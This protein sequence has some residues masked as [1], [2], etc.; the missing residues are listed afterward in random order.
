MTVN[1][2]KPNSLVSDVVEYYL[3]TKAFARLKG[4]TQKE[5]EGSLKIALETKTLLGKTL[6]DTRLNKLE[7]KCANHLY[8]Q[9]LDRGISR[10]NKIST[11]TSIIFNKAISLKI[12]Y[13]NPMI[14]IDRV[15]N[16]ERKVMWTPEQVNLFLD[17]AYSQWKWRPI[18]LIVHMT[19]EWAQRLGDMRLM[20]WDKID[21]DKK[22]MDLTQSKRNADVH[23]PISNEL[24]HVLEQQYKS[25][26]FQDFVAPQIVHSD[27]LYK[28]YMKGNLSSY[29][30]S[31]KE[32]AGLPAE[33]TA[34]DMRRTAITEMVEAGVDVLQIKQVSGHKNIQSLD[35][36]LKHTFSGA[37]SALAQRQAHKVKEDT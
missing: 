12:L 15:P 31:V 16:K 35:P 29:I 27:G 21:L 24:M 32:A 8:E 14:G 3:N 5:Y 17:T 19:Y 30:N 36:Y 6:G 28:P 26:G 18:G 25:F 7:T 2:L 34:M 37:S 13:Y 9:W 10:A 4:S 11:I 33:L 23:L 1:K 22:R 20:T